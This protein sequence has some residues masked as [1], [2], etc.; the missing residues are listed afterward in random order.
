MVFD[1]V[2]KVTKRRMLCAWQ[3]AIERDEFNDD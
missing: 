2:F 3:V 1:K